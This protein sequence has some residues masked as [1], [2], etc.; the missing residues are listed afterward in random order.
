M[1]NEELLSKYNDSFKTD[2]SMMTGQNS[3]PKGSV[4]RRSPF[5]GGGGGMLSPMNTGDS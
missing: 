4:G 5:G 3:R 2:S 1:T